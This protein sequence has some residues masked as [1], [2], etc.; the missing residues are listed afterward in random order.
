MNEAQAVL[1]APVTDLRGVGAVLAARLQKLGIQTL[2]DLLLHLPLRYQDRSRI[3][4]VSQLRPGMHAQFVGRIVQAQ[5]LHRRKRILQCVLEQD[6]ARVT[7]TFFRFYRNQLKQMQAGKALFCA[8]EIRAG[9]HG[10]PEC[11]HPEWKVLTDGRPR[12]PACDHYTPIY[13]VV[14]GLN[15]ALLH[16]VLE[17]A[18]ARL[19][20]SL[21]PALPPLPGEDQ[22]LDLA[23]ALRWLHR[24]PLAWPQAELPARLEPARRRLAAEEL[25]AHAL[26]LQQ[27]RRRLQQHPAPVLVTSTESQDAFLAHLPFEPTRAQWRVLEEIRRDLARDRPMLRLL[28]GDVGAG[29]TLV[30]A[31]AAL[32]A[33]DS[34]CQVAVLAPTD[35]LAEQHYQQFRQ[36]FEPLGHAVVHLSS[37]LGSRDKRQALQAIAAGAPVVT[38]THALLE[39]T[40]A[41]SRLGLAIIDEQHRFGVHQRLR[42]RDKGE[43]AGLR[44]HQ[45][46]MTATP[47]PRTLAMTAYADLDV[48]VIDELPPGRTP[49]ETRVISNQRR[50]EVIDRI[51]AFCA[52][53]QQVYWVCTLIEESEKI[54]AQ[55]AE[56]TCRQ[57]QQALPELHVALLHGRMKAEEK[58]QVM[59][60]FKAGEVQLL[61]ATTVIEVGVDV[62]NA[63]LMII[64]NA[65]RLGLAQLHQLRGRVGRGQAKSHCLLLYEPGLSETARARLET[66]RAT[67]DGFA[68][69]QRD[70]ELRGPG[71][72]LGTRQKGALQFRVADLEQHRDLIPWANE[73]AAM[74]LQQQ[75]LQAEGVRERWFPE[76][77]QY[78]A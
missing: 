4:P 1:Q 27:L 7:L 75:P 43:A 58:Q 78:A 37:R 25:L 70:L 20:D 30:A 52:R 39:D 50:D 53:G 65:E 44:P 41:F 10:R 16:D 42:L 64:E 28:Q 31:L 24:P 69:A 2:F 9:F 54:Q 13:P 22:A 29:K 55:A 45:L 12:L 63:T 48:S 38:G 57:L 19:P 23:Q 36:W 73:Q 17:Q 5:V 21:P 62:P 35:V 32:A 72:L 76:T 8:G 77:D 14:D 67:T 15:Q 59:Q 47:I 46:I 51:R 71:E 6:G 40:V 74:L 18:L 3:T 33:V 68:I 49:V 60:A 56:D 11:I 66:M 26:G 34:G 61:V